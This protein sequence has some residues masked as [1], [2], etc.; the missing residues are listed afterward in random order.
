MPVNETHDD[1]AEAATGWR[2]PVFVAW[3]ATGFAAGTGLAVGLAFATGRS[4]V[5]VAEMT[6][7]SAIAFFAVALA[8]K[9]VTGEETLTFYHHAL[10]VSLASMAVLI[11][12]DKPVLP[13]FELAILGLLTFLVFGR[14]GC[15]FVGC[16]HGR[17]HEWGVVYPAQPEGGGL[18]AYLVGVILLPVQLFE[19]IASAVIVLVGSMAVLRGWPAGTAVVWCVCAYATARF[20]IEF[21]RGDD[22]RRYWAGSSV[23][24]WT[25]LV[26]SGCC[27]VLALFGL[28]P[29]PV[30]AIGVTVAL[31]A[32][33]LGMAARRRRSP[34]A[35]F[36]LLGAH[37]AHE[38]G[39]VLDLG[40]ATGLP[41][42]GLRVR[43]TGHGLAVSTSMVLDN[44][45]SA[46]LY[47][48]SHADCRLDGPTATRLAR[49]V[50]LLRHRG[51]EWRVLAGSA[52][53]TLHVL[54]DQS[55]ARFRLADLQ[56][57]AAGGIGVGEL[58][59]AVPQ[60]RGLNQ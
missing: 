5:V 24:Q 23:P 44:G 10:A 13:Y 11:A 53:G 37:H 29:Y 26:L 7:A 51:R 39:H 46:R 45:R 48:M 25:S 2:V 9:A 59:P 58:Q 3:G 34:I 4:A 31:A 15:Y 32:A 33:A 16:C 36:D 49:L 54:V 18:P 56:Q 28:L 17:P 52:P 35:R 43:Q 6:V 12:A 21:G 1:V 40:I 22:A 8:T 41:A 47:T 19:V 27:S 30:V 50:V 38:L 14:M 20:V 57:L 60:A 42:D 55:T